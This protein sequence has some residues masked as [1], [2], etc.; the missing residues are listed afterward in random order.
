VQKTSW[1]PA[2]VL[3]LSRKG[4]LG[5]DADADIA[6]IDPRS[7]R[8][9]TTICGGK[10]VLHNDA[11]VGHGSTVLTSATGAAAVEHSGCQPYVIDLTQAGFY[12]GNGLKA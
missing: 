2:R 1:T 11:V 3:G 9:I 10:L 4:Q 8:A 7:R 12:T 6:V 5:P